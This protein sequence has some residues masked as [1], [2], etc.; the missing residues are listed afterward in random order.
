MCHTVLSADRELFYLYMGRGYLL[1]RKAIH[2]CKDGY[3]ISPI[4]KTPLAT[5]LTNVNGEMFAIKMG[6]ELAGVRMQ[7]ISLELP[8]LNLNLRPHQIK[9]KLKAGYHIS[10][11]ST[12]VENSLIYL[13]L[14]NEYDVTFFDGVD[15]SVATF[16]LLN[17][18]MLQRMF[19]NSKEERSPAANK[20]GE[21]WIEELGGRNDWLYHKLARKFG[22]REEEDE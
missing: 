9:I 3:P 21:K 1:G 13:V 17:K 8:T 4:Q 10:P 2:L 19:E 7:D 18:R 6:D 15:V 20:A 16:Y 22:I 14:F 5:N 12:Y 11:L